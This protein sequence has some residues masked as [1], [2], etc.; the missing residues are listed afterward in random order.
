[1]PVLFSDMGRS[2][3][4]M[5]EPGAQEENI[6]NSQSLGKN[7]SIKRSPGLILKRL[8]CTTAFKFVFKL[9]LAPVLLAPLLFSIY[10]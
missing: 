1:M 2:G 7:K 5:P 8:F 3:V 6:L 9:L 10:L 4:G